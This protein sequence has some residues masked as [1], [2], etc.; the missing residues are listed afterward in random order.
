MKNH[1]GMW[2][3]DGDTFFINRTDYESHDYGVLQNYLTN[4]RIA[5]DIGAHVGYW[6]K[7][8]VNDFEYVY[9]FEAAAEHAECLRLNVTAENYELHNI[10][11]SNQLG[12]V[13]FT[14]NVDNSGMS[15]VDD[16]GEEI[17]CQRLDHW[18][19]D[20][21]DLIKID[22]EGHELQVLQGAAE[23]IQRCKPVL[24]VEILNSTPTATRDSI[25]SLLTSWGYTQV[26]TVAE[27]YIFVVSQ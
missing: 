3:P 15:H 8:L 6:T 7:R 2:L 14:R 5:V 17:F 12:T 24:F 9:A 22:V 25:T 26:Q 10:A 16:S 4:K 13:R 11:V 21:V 27:N 18:Q 19:L 20:S 1:N 23:T